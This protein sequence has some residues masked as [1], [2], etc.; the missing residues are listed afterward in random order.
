M[1]ASNIHFFVRLGIAP[2]TA[3]NSTIRYAKKIAANT[4]LQEEF[5][6][7]CYR[8]KSKDYA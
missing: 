2:A 8:L 5:E 4:K 1:P 3:S 7:L 6:A